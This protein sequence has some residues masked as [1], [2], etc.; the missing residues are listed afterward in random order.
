MFSLAFSGLRS[1]FERHV[2]ARLH[3]RRMSALMTMMWRRPRLHSKETFLHDD[4][5]KEPSDFSCE[6]NLMPAPVVEHCYRGTI[7]YFCP[8]SHA[9]LFGLAKCI[10]CQNRLHC[11]LLPCFNYET[12]A[13]NGQLGPP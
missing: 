5:T 3:F 1:L 12:A 13:Y 10:L 2:S 7:L 6:T 9:F 8:K 11:S 4:A